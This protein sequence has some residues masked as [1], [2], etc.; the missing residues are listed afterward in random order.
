MRLKSDYLSMV[1]KIKRN[2]VHTCRW[3]RTPKHIRCCY[4]TKSRRIYCRPDR[5]H[6]VLRH[7]SCVTMVYGTNRVTRLKRTNRT[8][9]QTIG[10][11]EFANLRYDNRG[12]IAV[13]ICRVLEKLVWQGHPVTPKKTESAQLPFTCKFSIELRRITYNT[14]RL[15]DTDTHMSYVFMTSS[16]LCH[17][18]HLDSFLLMQVVSNQ[19]LHSQQV[20]LLV[21]TAFSS[22]K[23]QSH[24]NTVHNCALLSIW[25]VL[26]QII[27]HFQ[28]KFCSS[29]S[30]NSITPS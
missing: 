16:I 7:I 15:F 23:W 3:H 27:P 10:Q 11:R 18:L 20:Q 4:C 28:V 13:G 21:P 19:C 1:S 8:A 30:S 9:I 25:R 6:G 29:F 14:I 26:P 24:Q 5:M 17:Y 22:S 12:E 2:R